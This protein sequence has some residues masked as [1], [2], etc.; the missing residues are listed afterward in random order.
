MLE[1]ALNFVPVYVLVLF[2]IAGMMVWAPLLGSQ[3]IPKRI[4]ALMACVL[5][6]GVTPGLSL[7]VSLPQTA[8]GLALAIG[9]E[10][11]FGAAMGMILSLI[12]IA[13]Q[14]AGEIIGQQM[15]LSLGQTF[16][17]QYGAN[18]SMIGDVYFFLALLIFLG[19][20]G[21]HAML[22]GVYDSF[23]VLPLASVG[24]DRPLF[25]MLIGLFQGATVLAMQ[26][27]APILVTMLVL[28]VVLGFV[29][30][31]VPQLNIMTAGISLRSLVGIAV[32]VVGLSM[33]SSVLRNSLFGAM[34][35]V[36]QGYTTR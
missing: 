24:M 9:G 36:Y 26:L 10:I 17:P 12:F 13:A 2:R 14:W 3:Q 4:K 28:D 6:A 29:G 11:I 34:K 35:A 25:G 19:I 21:H 8:W 20:N 23:Q 16:D 27:A 30:K 31:T 5:A 18:G 7:S 1:A 32:L 33:T 15:G 22:Q